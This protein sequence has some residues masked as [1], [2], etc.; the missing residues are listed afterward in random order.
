MIP[1]KVQQS[2]SAYLPKG[3][4]L[5]QQGVQT[6]T[7]TDFLLGVERADDAEQDDAEECEADVG[8]GVDP[9]RVPLGPIL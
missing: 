5:Y 7:K 8:D 3:L 9:V 1:S 6:R 2:S 4:E